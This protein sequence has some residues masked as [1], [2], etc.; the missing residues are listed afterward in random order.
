MPLPTTM[1][2]ELPVDLEV[3]TWRIAYAAGDDLGAYVFEV[4]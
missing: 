1:T 3:G 4:R 2:I